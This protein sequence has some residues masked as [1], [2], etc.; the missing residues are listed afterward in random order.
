M[1]N[2]LGQRL[3]RPEDYVRILEAETPDERK[4]YVH[5]R[6][7]LTLLHNNTISIDSGTDGI[8]QD[9]LLGLAAANEKGTLRPPLSDQMATNLNTF[10]EEGHDS[11]GTAARLMLRK[12]LIEDSRPSLQPLPDR[13]FRSWGS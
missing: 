7:A 6:Y 8:V 4:P 5:A 10:I 13:G 2:E 12:I 11:T 1:I 3:V 9:A